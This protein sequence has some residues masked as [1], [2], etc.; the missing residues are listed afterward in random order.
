MWPLASLLTEGL[1]SRSPD[2]HALLSWIRGRGLRR[3][4]SAIRIV[5]GEL[6]A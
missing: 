2:N 3:S 4:Y 1:T 6:R 5:R